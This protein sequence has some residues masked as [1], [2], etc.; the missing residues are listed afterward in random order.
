MYESEF[1]E[2]IP[3]ITKINEIIKKYRIEYFVQDLD[4]KY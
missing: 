2:L 4:V 1:K 3:Y